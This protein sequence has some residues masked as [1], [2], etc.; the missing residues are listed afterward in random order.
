[1]VEEEKIKECVACKSDKEVLFLF[2]KDNN[3]GLSKSVDII[4][5][6]DE[7]NR[8]H[9]CP[10][11]NFSRLHGHQTRSNEARRGV[12]FTRSAKFY[13]THRRSPPPRHVIPFTRRCF[14]RM[15]RPHHSPLHHWFHP[16]LQEVYDAPAI[17]FTSFIL[18]TAAAA[19]AT[20]TKTTTATDDG[21]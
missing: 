19:V 16:R 1:M 5:A 4:G 7:V 6:S 13:Y 12:L 3:V 17:A 18:R 10:C 2:F 20:M 11:T 21:A 15:A 9:V 14:T 8:H